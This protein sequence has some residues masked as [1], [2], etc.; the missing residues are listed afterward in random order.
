[1]KR[2]IEI[3]AAMGDD[4]AG[5]EDVNAPDPVIEKWRELGMGLLGSSFI[6]VAFF[7]AWTFWEGYVGFLDMLPM[8]APAYVMYF[9]VPV[10]GFLKFPWVR[11]FPWAVPA[12]LAYLFR[13][14]LKYSRLGKLRYPVAALFSLWRAYGFGAT[15]ILF[16]NYR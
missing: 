12:A 10:W 14:A 16:A 4:P 6:Y 5:N 13:L 7:A 9:V 3:L 15:F 1:M 11:V 8:L 2:W